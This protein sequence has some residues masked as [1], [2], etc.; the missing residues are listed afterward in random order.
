MS[1]Q[2]NIQFAQTSDRH[3]IAY[4]VSGRGYPLVR[5]A[6]W[7]SHVEADWRTSLFAP[8]Y[9]ELSA[10]YHLYRYDSRGYGLSDGNDTEISVDSLVVDLAAVVDHAKLGQFSLWG[11]TSSSSVTAIAYAALY[12]ERVSH[13]VLSAPI[14]RGVFRRANSTHE[15]KERR[16]AFLKLVEHGWGADNPAF[17]QIQST[18]MFPEATADQLAELNELYRMAAPPAHAARMVKATSEADVSGFLPRITCPVLLLH[19]R[20]AE[21][22]PIEEVRLIASSLP[23]ARFVQ[24]ATRNYIPLKGEPAF[25]VLLDEIKTFL[26]R[27]LHAP[28]SNPAVDSLTRREREVL[29][30][31]ARGL[32]NGSIASHLGLS[33]KTVRNIMSN[34]FDKLAVKSRTQAVLL[35]RKAGLGD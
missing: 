29:D 28:S 14:A 13:L 17:R 7:F 16:S 27:A 1:F 22:M 20:G 34:I 35:A 23:E 8:L 15:E 2:Q 31:L 12:P 25:K 33:E 11:S 30:L 26:P 10:C 32:N 18:Q 19:C 21:L 3:R 24:L 5:A 9:S 4:A 6:T